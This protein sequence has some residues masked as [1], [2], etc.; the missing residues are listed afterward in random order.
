MQSGEQ[1][2]PFEVRD[3]H[4]A[5][6]IA[7]PLRL[8]I[9]LACAL[10]ERSLSHLH[11]ELAIP[12]PKLHY[13]AKR[14]NAAGLLTISRVQARAGR[15]IRFYRAIASSFLVAQD[16]LQTLPGDQWADRLRQALRDERHREPEQ[17][18][19]YT[20]EAGGKVLARIV[21]NQP[22]APSRTLE[23]WRTVRLDPGQ[24]TSL[25]RELRDL[26]E[27][28]AAAGSHDDGDLYLVHAAFAPRPLAD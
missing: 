26:L 2:R 15:A 25:A 21:R 14:L 5:S 12:L 17:S 27:R 7:S 20:A 4:Q 6:L 28:Y 19:L 8:R 16:A 10:E 13:H 18:L 24:R 23:L 1:S 22:P 9:L 3:P 11:Q